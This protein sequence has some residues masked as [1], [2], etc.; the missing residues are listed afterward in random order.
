MLDLAPGARATGSLSFTVND[1]DHLGDHELHNIV[2]SDAPGSECP[3]G[4][5]DPEL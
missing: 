1:S 3:T 2:A 4:L 5:G